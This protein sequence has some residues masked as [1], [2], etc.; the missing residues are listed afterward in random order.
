MSFRKQ[1]L[2]S[3]IRNEVARAMQKEVDFPV[4]ALASVTEVR[5][6]QDLDYAD[7]MIS[8]F[9]SN[10]KDGALK[11]LNAKRAEIQTI[12]FKKMN[13]A[14]LPKLRFNHD[15]GSEKSANIERIALG[16]K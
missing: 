7:V 15:P 10:K 1:Q 11:A 8:V 2:N 6:S 5:V 16:D 14:T 9:P 12:L 13:I 4:G 3:L